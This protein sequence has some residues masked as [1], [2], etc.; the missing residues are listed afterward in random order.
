MAA[1][2]GEGST[3]SGSGS[4]RAGS[5][6]SSTSSCWHAAR[7]WT[8]NA[9]PMAEPGQGL[10][11]E[12]PAP[13]P[14]EVPGDGSGAAAAA[15]WRRRVRGAADARQVPLA[16]ILTTV[17]V[18]VATG[19]VLLLLWVLRIECALP[20][21]GGLRRPGPPPPG[22][23]GRPSRD[24]PRRGHHGGLHPRA[25][26]L[27]RRG[28]PLFGAPGHRGH[29]AGPQVPRSSARPSTAGG[30]IGRL[31]KRFHLQSWVSQNAPR[32]TSDVTKILKPA[33]ALSVGAAAAST[34]FGLVTI[35]VLSFF[36][37]LEVPRCGAASC[38]CCRPERAA[39]V[40]RARPRCPA[41]SAATC[42]GTSS[43]RWSPG[44]SS[45]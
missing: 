20:A 38:R 5:T 26:G 12:H 27:R 29:P 11:H 25:A 28:L 18:V 3:G 7:T 32:L 1:S 8:C 40:R 34:L 42:W 4:G 35:A 33:Q 30:Q 17:A 31:I 21:G 15:A 41:R 2:R 24:A 44:W 36:V 14:A 22:P 39:Q 16:T 23:G 9:G 43:P 13:G 45:S 6:G 19:L 10:H 37:L